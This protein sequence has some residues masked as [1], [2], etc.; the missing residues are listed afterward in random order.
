MTHT[1]MAAAAA[2]AI[3][4]AGW[5][6]Q[7]HANL[8]ITLTGT[9]TSATET[10]YVPTLVPHVLVGT[11]YDGSPKYQDMYDYGRPVPY[12]S[13][14]SSQGGLSVGG[15]VTLQL[16]LDEATLT[17]MSG[18]LTQGSTAYGLP[19]KAPIYTSP[20]SF[21]SGGGVLVPDGG[22]AGSINAAFFLQAMLNFSGAATAG[23]PLPAEFL[24]AVQAGGFTGG[25]SQLQYKGSCYSYMSYIGY[26]TQLSC[27]AVNLTFDQITVSLGGQSV[28][29]QAVPE[30]GTWALMGLGLV[31]LVSVRRRS[32][33]G[34]R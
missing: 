4:M 11:N 32:G 21:S 24:T 19:G 20:Q 10:Q 13:S 26:N 25:T 29:A 14:A 28:T 23:K 9:V 30:P 12:T 33:S 5:T 17:A 7:A 22:N 16:S 31:G 6:G 1:Q 27:G 15:P 2:F 8:D 34:L 18:S 3:G